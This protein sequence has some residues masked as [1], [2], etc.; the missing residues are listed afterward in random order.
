[1]SKL[2]FSNWCLGVLLLAAWTQTPALPPQTPPPGAQP[3]GC[4]CNSTDA[5][6]TAA[7]LAC[8][9]GLQLACDCQKQ[10]QMCINPTLFNRPGLVKWIMQKP[11]TKN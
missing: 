4:R 9:S 2:K 5:V 3:L 6:P 10:Q 8:Q 7:S 11:P 1:M